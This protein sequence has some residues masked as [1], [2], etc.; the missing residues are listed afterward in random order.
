ML[1]IHTCFDQILRGSQQKQKKIIRNNQKFLM[2]SR[3]GNFT[4]HLLKKELQALNTLVQLINKNDAFPICENQGE[5]TQHLK[6]AENF[7]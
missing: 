3:N 6:L 4:V 2:L 1:N 7:H 5:K